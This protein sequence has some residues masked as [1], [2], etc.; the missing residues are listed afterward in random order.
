VGQAENEGEKNDIFQPA[1]K[2]VNEE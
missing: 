2:I 1:H